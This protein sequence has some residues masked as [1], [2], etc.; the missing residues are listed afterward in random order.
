MRVHVKDASFVLGATDPA[1]VPTI[2]MVPEIAVVGRSNV[3]KS[4]LINRMTGRTKLART[5]GT[6]GQTQQLNLFL[7]RYAVD[8]APERRLHLV[9]LPGFGY[10]KLSHDRREALGRL[11]VEYLRTR[12]D[13]AAVCLLNDCRRDPDRDEFAIRDL[14]FE[15]GAHLVVVL[16]KS[17][18]LGKNER[19]KRVEEV[20]RAYGLEAEDLVLTGEKMDPTPLWQ[21]LHAITATGEEC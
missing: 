18:K 15:A 5:S 1:A 21:R 16:T 6:P 17:D 12:E 8:D 14:A 9:D 10:A 20:A 3:G 2:E 11:I 19:R 13:L 7:L 4:S